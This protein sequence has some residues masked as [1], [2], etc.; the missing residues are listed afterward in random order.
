M[1][2]KSMESDIINTMQTVQIINN[3]VALAQLVVVSA[4]CL[5]LTDIKAD[6]DV[7]DVVDAL[8]GPSGPSGPIVTTSLAPSITFADVAGHDA[9]KQELIEVV[10]FI[11]DPARFVALGARVPRGILLTGGPGLGK[12]MLAKAVASEA[13]VSF[14]CTSASEFIEMYVGVGAQRVR[15]LFERARAA[16]GFCIIFIDEID[17]IGR[18]RADSYDSRDSDSEREQTINQLLTE[19]DGLN[20]NTGILV[21]AATNRFDILD[22]A[23]TRP[24]RFDRVIELQAPD[25]KARKE[26]LTSHASHASHMP[27]ADDV[28]D[29]FWDDIVAST[30]GFSGAE[31]ANLLNESALIAARREPLS[32]ASASASASVS[33]ADIDAAFD[34]V[35]LGVANPCDTRSKKERWLCAYHEAG[36]AIVAYK[37]GF[38]TIQKISIIG[39][40]MNSGGITM[41]TPKSQLPA[42]D[43]LDAHL[44]TILGGRAAEA[45]VVGGDQVT[46]GASSDLAAAEELAREMICKYSFGDQERFGTSAL[47]SPDLSEAT[48]ARVD[49][50]VRSLTIDAMKRATTILNANKEL[51]KRVAEKLIADGKMTG[52]EL[53]AIDS[54]MHRHRH[55]YRQQ[56]QRDM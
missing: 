44:A 21:M 5:V 32:E 17:A 52:K 22:P 47:T 40:I 36:H 18:D 31:L 27:F 49:G 12:T 25:A 30:V 20:D 38:A 3:V 2:N 50:A 39:T 45:I 28:D 15:S 6:C 23:L 34:R 53:L 10:E 55:R 33:A 24:G 13:G 14:I 26:L 11:K 41:F 7:V 9:A 43:D 8:S 51:L 48:R 4:T 56:Q 16:D 19:M 46:T 29:A 1:S 37:T 35:L 42:R 54:R